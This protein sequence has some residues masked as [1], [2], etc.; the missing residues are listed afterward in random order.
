MGYEAHVYT[1]KKVDEL[2]KEIKDLKK[3]VEDLEQKVG[4]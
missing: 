3:R 2:I 4:P 1:K